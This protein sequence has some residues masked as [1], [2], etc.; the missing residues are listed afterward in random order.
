MSY[1][2]MYSD[3]V[4][5]SVTFL[6]SWYLNPGATDWP[7]GF[8]WC[9]FFFLCLVQHT[10]ITHPAESNLS[11]DNCSLVAVTFMLFQ[12]LTVYAC[13]MYFRM[14]QSSLP[15]GF[16]SKLVHKKR[17][18]TLILPSGA[19][20]VCEPNNLKSKCQYLIS[21]DTADD[22]LKTR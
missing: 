4:I 1:F 21:Q 9:W 20:C 6:I 14:A 13:Q 10:C 19:C 5:T 15:H 22:G 12:P 16:F 7:P 17:S 18:Y 3:D 8:V 2:S 11:F